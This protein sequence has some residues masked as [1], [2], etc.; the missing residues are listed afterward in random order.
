MPRNAIAENI[1]NS[2]MLWW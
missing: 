2:S 1:M